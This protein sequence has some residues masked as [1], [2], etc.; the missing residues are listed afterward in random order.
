REQ[1]SRPPE[2]WDRM[3]GQVQVSIAENNMDGLGAS[4]EEIMNRLGMDTDRDIDTPEDLACLCVDVGRKLLDQEKSPN[5]ERLGE[6]ALSIDPACAGAHLLL[7]DV[8]LDSGRVS[9]AIEH[10]EHASHTGDP[11]AQIEERLARMR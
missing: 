10:L 6:A 1:D 4:L 5:A 2:D 7:A 11:V 8:Y 9:F 3:T